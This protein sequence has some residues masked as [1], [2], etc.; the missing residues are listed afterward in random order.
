VIV[1]RVGSTVTVPRGVGFDPGGIGKG[2]AVDLVVEALTRDGADG[3]CVNVGGDLRV[4]GISPAG[5]PWVAGVE[6][7]TRSR[8]AALLSLTRGAVATSTRTRRTWGPANDRR[9]HLIDPATG[10][11]TVTRVVSAT[12]VASEGW[13][14]EVLAKAAFLAGPGDGLALL[15]RPG[16]R[17]RRPGG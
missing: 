8:L 4:E 10:R 2:F 1:D 7:P 3:V 13:Q 16:S 12:A 15:E 11:P 14:A 6:H 5:G 17:D 9:H